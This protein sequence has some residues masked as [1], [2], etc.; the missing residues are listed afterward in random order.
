L[1]KPNLRFEN[2]P[3]SRRSVRFNFF[4]VEVKMKLP[5]DRFKLARVLESISDYQSAV[6]AGIIFLPM[7]AT[8]GCSSAIT[9][10]AASTPL[11]NKT[12]MTNPSI[13]ITPGNPTV[14]PGANIQFSALVSNTSDT[15]VYWSASGGVISGN[16]MFTVPKAQ[17]GTVFQIV[18]TSRADSTA[19]AI[20]NV[21]VTSSSSSP[22]NPTNPGSGS[23][24]AT[25]PDNRYCNAGDVPN[26]GTVDGP[27]AAP[28]ACFMTAEESTPS[29]G[30]VI[31]VSSASNLQTAI[32]NA[33][34]G[35]TLVLQAGQ[36]YP[37]FTLRAKSC[38]A[39]HY[40]TIR[41]SA[42]GS[43]LPAEG[44]RATPCNAG[45]SSL[46]GRPAL[47]CASTSNVMARIAGAAKQDR[48]IG[49]DAGA[50]YYR[51]MG[52]EVA[53]TEAN[54]A[55]AGFYDLILLDTADH[56]IFD[57]CW[58]HG[59]P[60]GEDI[61]GVEFTNSSYI[62]VIDSYISDIHSKVSG[63]GAD[64]AAIGSITGIG[65]VKIVDNF[66]EASGENVLWGGGASTTNV[67]DVEMRRNHLFK[68]F[69]WWK[70]SPTY[71]GT[72]FVVKNLY[73]SKTGV[74]QF[75]EG[76]I[77]ENNWAMAQKGTGILFT[78]KNQYG[79]CP[80]CTVHDIIFRYNILR[81]S[82]DGIGMAP[83]Y[84]TTCPGE[85][86]G[87]NGNCLYLSG[88]LYNLSVHDN[89]LD[90][91]NEST[92]SPG[93]CC[94]DGFLFNIATDQPTNWPHDILINHNTGFPV[95]SGIANVTIVSAPQVFANFSITNNLMTTG[96]G[97]FHQ[98]LPGNKQ[99]GCGTTSAAGMIGTLDG[100]MGD[101]WT[102]AGNVFANTSVSKSSKLAGSPLPARNFEAPGWESV[103]F[104]DF[105][106]GNG[107]NYQLSPSSPYKNA[108]TDGKD[109]GADID[110]LQTATAGVL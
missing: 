10:A 29:P 107:G 55:S 17:V 38:D 79:R 73:E 97:G 72:L 20:A 61:K 102:A 58:I 11:T 56:I 83:V 9:P 7:L 62:A 25:G 101:T 69:T 4:R 41:S 8:V 54:G 87:G 36:T 3:A 75:V 100:C 26:F 40:I 91:I 16:G 13:Q 35:E 88:G 46:P 48:I 18:A 64:S 45:V 106:S 27:A 78:P 110:G 70:L 65:P 42:A 82:V 93:T 22:T 24:P 49:T 95:G 92:Y 89:L 80:E 53:D 43:G 108:G 2:A 1:I 109:P 52:L 12:A 51:L 33:T 5:L 14:A 57:R 32:D 85:G 37:G 105:N 50:N 39:N 44:V 104:V 23:I 90:D 99:P 66:L 60:I 28:T 74:R 59:S 30:A 47:N 96:D 84:A 21:A 31:K 68:P 86:G 94:S 71:M 19:Y 67:S 63:Y 34:C 98:V 6:F 15:A 76:N 81:H 103:G 77:F